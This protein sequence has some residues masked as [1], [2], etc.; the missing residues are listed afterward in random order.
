[1]ILNGLQDMENGGVLTV[2]TEVRLGDELCRIT[3]ADSGT[4]ISK[5]LQEKLF[6]PF[7]TTTE[8]GTGLGLAVSYGIVKDH[9]GDIRVESTPGEGTAFV[10]LLPLRQ[11]LQSIV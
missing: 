9:G 1:M 7:F 8:R 3:I 6:T 11:T 5:E 10:V 4:G 2:G